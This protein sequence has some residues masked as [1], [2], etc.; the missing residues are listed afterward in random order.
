MDFVLC[1]EAK[2][3]PLGIIATPEFL[4]FTTDRTLGV[5]FIIATVEL[6]QFELEW[7]VVVRTSGHAVLP[8]LLH[9][10]MRLFCSPDHESHSVRVAFVP[11]SVTT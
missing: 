11:S 9:D 7:P 10:P 6:M 4:L 1:P 5:Q 2:K 8:E 3:V